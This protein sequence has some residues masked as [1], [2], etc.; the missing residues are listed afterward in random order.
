[1]QIITRRKISVPCM[2]QI[3]VSK[4]TSMRRRK[5]NRA[6]KLYE[7]TQFCLIANEKRTHS[8][9]LRYSPLRYR[10]FPLFLLSRQH[11]RMRRV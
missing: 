2:F 3:A 4:A 1:M 5:Y 9:A 7:S 11:V 6:W 8:R 10:I